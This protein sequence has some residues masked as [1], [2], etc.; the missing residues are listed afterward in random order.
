MRYPY[1]RSPKTSLLYLHHR[2]HITYTR[3]SVNE[4]CFYP[5]AEMFSAR[6]SGITFRELMHAPCTLQQIVICGTL[7]IQLGRVWCVA[8]INVSSIC[9]TTIVLIAITNKER[10]L[11]RSDTA[12]AWLVGS[13]GCGW[14]VL[15]L[16]MEQRAQTEDQRAQKTH[17]HRPHPS[18]S[19]GFPLSAPGGRPSSCC[20]RLW[21]WWA[22]Q[23][24]ELPTLYS[25][26]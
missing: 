26:F 9:Q 11:P 12:S 14:Y 1:S 24:P 21:V 5:S 20:Q 2:S 16:Q 15:Q 7:H 19:S 18:P 17:S 23:R 6:I 10:G 13:R 22:A 4:Y 8:T 3:Q 25:T